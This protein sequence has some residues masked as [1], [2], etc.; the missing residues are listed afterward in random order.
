LT[1][2][3]A[4]VLV[5]ATVISRLDYC[6]TLLTGLPV[7]ILKPLQAI[8]NASARLILKQPKRAHVT[9]LLVHLHWLPI[10]TRFRFKSLC[11]AYRSI[12]NLAPSYL[13]PLFHVY[14]PSRTLRSSQKQLLVIPSQKGKKSLNKTFAFN[15][16]RWW[17]G[18]SDSTRSAESFEAFKKALKTC[19]FK[20]H[21][22]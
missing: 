8:Q 9:H 10:I 16:S 20:E 22:S 15:V 18:L 13:K 17:N 12:S 3:I 4:Q 11:L 21:L 7:S 19:L 14:S 1:E 5:Q 2:E 6:N